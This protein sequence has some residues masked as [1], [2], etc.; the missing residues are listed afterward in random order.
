MSS[1]LIRDTHLRVGFLLVRAA[2]A[3][4][5]PPVVSHSLF[6]IFSRALAKLHQKHFIVQAALARF[7]WMTPATT[8]G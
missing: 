5:V 8:T 7:S 1:Q 6:W 2:G 4:L 3:G